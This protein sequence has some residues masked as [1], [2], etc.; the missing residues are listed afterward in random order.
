MP[1][2]R[3]GITFPF[4]DS[5]EGFFLGLN[6]DTDSEVRSNLI[7]LILTPKGSRYF[8][9]DFG[10][11]LSKYIFELMDT[12]TKISIEKEIREAV[13]KYIPTLTINNVEVKSAE[14]L[15]A[16]EKLNEQSTDLSMDDGN[17]S[18]VGESQRNYSLRVR[19]DYTA[20]DGVFETKDFVIIDL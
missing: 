9:P 5:S 16:E 2:Q 20:G 1:T 11:N 4:V 13:N 3:Y 7:H 19:I 15:K 8:L 17:M 6:T 14:D 18:F 10:T 12:T